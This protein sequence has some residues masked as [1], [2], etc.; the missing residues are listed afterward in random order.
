MFKF[1]YNL[2][3]RIQVRKCSKCGKFPLIRKRDLSLIPE[4]EKERQRG[5]KKYPLHNVYSISC[6][7]KQ[8]QFIDANDIYGAEF[9]VKIKDVRRIWNRKQR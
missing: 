8:A 3:E 9:K 1:I 2:I 5:N 4:A 6:C 7:G